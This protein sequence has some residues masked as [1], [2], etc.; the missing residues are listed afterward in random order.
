M[1]DV[2][3]KAVTARTA[4][5]AG[6][7]LLSAECVAALR[8]GSVPK[9][10]ALAVARIAGIQGAKRTPDLIPLCHPLPIS[11]VDVVDRG[12]RRRRRDH[13]HGED[14]RSHRGGDGGADRGQRRR[15]SAVIDMIK[16]IDRAAVIT[17][18]RVL[19]KSGGRRRRLE[20]SR[21]ADMI[22]TS[23][24]RPHRA[25]DHRLH[26]GRGR[27]VR[28]HAPGRSSSRRWPALGFEVS[29]PLVVADGDDGRRRVAIRGRGGVCG[30][31]HHRRHGA[32][33]PTITRPSRPVRCVEREIPHLAAAIA[34]VRSRS[35]SAD[36]RAQPGLAGTAG[37]TLIVNLPGSRGGARDGM[38]VA[39][40][41]AGA[42]GQPAAGWRPLR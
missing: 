31:D 36:G 22:R 11:G 19:A 13:R 3:A 32:R 40:P 29:E 17:D 7:V 28:R 39:R 37:R 15:R 8:D 35:W 38:A 41:G 12:D 21:P 20:S 33:S 25:S 14:H 26:P 16:A 2:S 18:V 9:G 6:R 23:R 10:D 4:T 5:A 27:R 42:R 24:E 30:G 1:V 34:R